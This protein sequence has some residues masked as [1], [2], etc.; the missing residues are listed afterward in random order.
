MRNIL[1]GFLIVVLAWGFYLDYAKEDFEIIEIPMPI[2][3]P[4]P[5]PVSGCFITED[6]FLICRL[7]D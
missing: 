2:A 5:T 7:E 6:K 3:E 1:A 4:Y